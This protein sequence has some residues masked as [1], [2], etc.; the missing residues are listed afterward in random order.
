M[1]NLNQIDLDNGGVTTLSIWMI[2]IIIN[3]VGSL[4]LPT[5]ML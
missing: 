5:F 1:I 2:S 4:K 3:L